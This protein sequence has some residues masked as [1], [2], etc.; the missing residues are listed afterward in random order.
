MHTD[1][2]NMGDA[3]YNDA[4]RAN[5]AVGQLTLRVDKLEETLQSLLDALEADGIITVEAP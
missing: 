5:A 4:R 2:W 3:A 1:G